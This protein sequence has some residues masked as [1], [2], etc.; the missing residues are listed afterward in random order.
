MSPFFQSR[1]ANSNRS[2][3]VREQ[4]TP[5]R[6]AR[7]GVLKPQL[8]LFC[9]DYLGCRGAPHKTPPPSLLQCHDISQHLPE[10]EQLLLSLLFRSSLRKMCFEKNGQATTSF[11]QEWFARTL[12]YCGFCQGC[13]S[14]FPRLNAEDWGKYCTSVTQMIK[15]PQRS[16]SIPWRCH[17]RGDPFQKRQAH[18]LLTKKSHHTSHLHTSE[19]VASF[20]F[21]GFGGGVII[22][23]LVL[24]HIACCS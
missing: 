12:D 7:F 6:T 16:R 18:H 23:F 15:G 5:V 22:T 3:P 9:L 2:P 10:V 17:Q 20:G 1:S 13:F 8:L 14:R 4:L 11:C 21:Q 24:G 19:A